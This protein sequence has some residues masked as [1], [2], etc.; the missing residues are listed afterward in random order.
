MPDQPFAGL[1]SQHPLHNQVGGFHLLVAGH[2]LDAAA[3]VVGGEE[4]EVG[5]EIKNHRRP[6]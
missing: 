2:H 4:R 1:T 5:E 3:L 6:Q